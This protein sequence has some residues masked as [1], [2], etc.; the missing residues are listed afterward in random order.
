MVYITLED[1]QAHHLEVLQVAH[2]SWHPSG[3]GSAG[4]RGPGLH[5]SCKLTPV[6]SQ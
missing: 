2:H 4:D 1:V 6:L 3:S 5:S